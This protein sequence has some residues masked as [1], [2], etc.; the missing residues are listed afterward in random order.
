RCW[1]CAQRASRRRRRLAGPSDGAVRLSD[2]R[3]ARCRRFLE[4]AGW[5]TA[6]RRVLAADA[7]F[8]RYDRL[9]RGNQRA[10]LM[11]APPPQENVK[12]FHHIAQCLLEMDL[13]APRPLAI[14]AEAGFLLLE[15]FGDL[16]FTRALKAGAD[17]AELYRLATDTLIA[18]HQR[19]G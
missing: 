11:D 18:L 17:E 10:V 16:T 3:E 12:V 15:D 6:E 9:T 2:D 7:S 5:G 1:R 19:W 13:S 8:R 4:S 14:D